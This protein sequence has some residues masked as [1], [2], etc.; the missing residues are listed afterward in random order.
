[1]A[2][3][4]DA[5]AVAGR[6]YLLANLAVA[7]STLF[8]GTTWW[9]LRQLAA[10]GFEGPWVAVLTYAVPV[11]AALPVALWRARMLAKGGWLL[12]AIGLLIGGSGMFYADGVL[13]GEVVRVL[14]LFYLMPVWS[15]LFERLFLG[16]PITLLRIGTIALG[17][18]GLVVL[19][20][21]ENGLPLPRSTGDWL[22]LASGVAWALGVV[23]L[24]I[25]AP[26]PDF[27]R[28]FAQFVGAVAVGLLL[29]PLVAMPLPPFPAGALS[30]AWHLLL[31]VAVFWLVPTAALS[32]WGAA[33]LSPVRSSLLFMLEVPT[34][35]IS[36]VLLAGEPFGLKEMVGGALILGAAAIDILLVPPGNAPERVRDEAR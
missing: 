10:Q 30:N 9:P 32:L 35:V 3:S 31:A 1:M 28:C 15:V 5:P 2:S 36:A 21:F 19:L 11:L 23:L 22:G 27:E 17:L 6:T 7:A 24:R 13:M 18:V 25:Q 34:G 20:G 29:M 8:W 12:V 16:T 14:L 26:M 33:R 4:P